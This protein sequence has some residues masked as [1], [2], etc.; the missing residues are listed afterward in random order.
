LHHGSTL[1]AP[2]G[3]ALLAQVA[4]HRLALRALQIHGVAMMMIFGATLRM[5]PSIVSG[6][7]PSEHLARRPRAR[8]RPAL[9]PGDRP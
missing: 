9:R 8:G 2:D 7:P 6:T 4:I 5:F 1:G 3:G